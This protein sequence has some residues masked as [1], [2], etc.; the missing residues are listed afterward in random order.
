MNESEKRMTIFNQIQKCIKEQYKI[1]IKYATE[2]EIT[3][4]EIC[5]LELFGNETMPSTM[6]LKAWCTLRNAPRSFRLDRIVECETTN[7]RFI[8]EEFV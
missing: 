5:P 4:R 3:E 1:K 2:D 7:E 6:L 8:I